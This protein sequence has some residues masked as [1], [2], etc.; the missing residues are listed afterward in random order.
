MRRIADTRALGASRNAYC[1]GLDDCTP[2]EQ[3]RLAAGALS[4]RVHAVRGSRGLVS[5]RPE[6]VGVRGGV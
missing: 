1:I 6:V 2:H 4:T 3:A 5:L